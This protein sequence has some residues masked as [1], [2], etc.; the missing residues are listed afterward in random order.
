MLRVYP[1][2]NRDVVIIEDAGITR[3]TLFQFLAGK[4]VSRRNFNTLCKLFKINPDEVKDLTDEIP[5]SED[6]GI[7]FNFNRQGTEAFQ[8]RS[9]L[10]NQIALALADETSST[11]VHL[12]GIGGVGKTTLALEYARLHLNVDTKYPGGICKFDSRSNIPAQIIDFAKRHL[13]LEIDDT[14]SI[15]ELVDHFYREWKPRGNALIIFDDLVEFENIKLY[16]PQRFIRYKVIVT[17]R[18]KNL[19]ANAIEI[20]VDTLSPE[21]SLQVLLQ[22]AGKETLNTYYAEKICKWLGYLPL[23]IEL[24]GRY[25]ALNPSKTFQNVF[26]SLEQKKLKHRSLKET[27]PNMTATRNVIAAFDLSFNELS[28]DERYLAFMLSMFALAPIPFEAV[29]QCL[30]NFPPEYVSDLLDLGLIN[31]SLLKS[32]DTDLYQMHE[33]IKEYFQAKLEDFSEND[34]DTTRSAVLPVWMKGENIVER[35]DLSE[36]DLT[37]FNNIQATESI[38]D[39]TPEFW[40]ELIQKKYV[41]G[42]RAA[43][44]SL[45]SQVAYDSRPGSFSLLLPHLTANYKMLTG[46]LEIEDLTR[47]NVLMFDV[48]TKLG[49]QK[50]FT[51]NL[52]GA[53]AD[54]TRS[55]LSDP[56][57]LVFTIS[58]YSMLG[59]IYLKLKNYD[60]AEAA[61]R[62]GLDAALKLEVT[63]RLEYQ[64]LW[65][66]AAALKVMVQL[67]E[68]ETIIISGFEF[69][70]HM[71]DKLGELNF[72]FDISPVNGILDC[73]VIVAKEVKPRNLRSSLEFRILAIADIIYSK[74]SYKTRFIVYEQLASIYE[75]F[76]KHEKSE[77]VLYHAIESANSLQENPCEAYCKLIDLMMVQGAGKETIEELEK[78]MEADIDQFFN[79]PDMPVLNDEEFYTPPVV[80]WFMSQLILPETPHKPD[81][82]Q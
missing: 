69:I 28:K 44:L 42:L 3:S 57:I 13:K 78:E 36:A 38:A 52:E 81:S 62:S 77:S 68:P 72:S 8:G 82:R 67:K 34:E 61:V 76:D 48:F 73:L 41:C 9:L 56:A 1:Q 21:D 51:K 49:E 64:L 37:E 79:D 20:A 27:F 65:V 32:V 40:Y 7:P 47:L 14:L 19:V 16:I 22:L 63:T 6:N 25:L 11:I 66:L 5:P 71:I 55:D 35:Y 59:D 80:I 54:H 12:H 15:F 33:L 70:E 17:S 2:R 26:E 29:D 39:K 45:V 75:C 53:L 30:F 23:A 50:E 43:S 18:I 31:R 24:V 4:K 60:K 46:E 10:L 74:T 58:T